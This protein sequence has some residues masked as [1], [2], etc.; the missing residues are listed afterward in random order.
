[1]D[2]TKKRGSAAEKAFFFAVASSFIFSLIYI[3]IRA[4]LDEIYRASTEYRIMIFQSA[5]GLAMINLPTIMRKLFD[6]NIPAGFSIIFLLFLWSAIFAGEVLQFYYRIPMWDDIL[7][8]ASSMMAT[9]LG[10]SLVYI[11]SGT[12]ASKDRHLSPLLVSVFSATF[13][14]FIGVLWE[15]YEYA[16]DGILSLN[17]QKFAV[18]SHG[19]PDILRD[20][21]GRAALTDTMNDL[22]VD[23]LGALIISILGYISLKRSGKLF[24]SF[25]IYVKTDTSNE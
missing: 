9:V 15:I 1:M 13:S 11:L 22:I 16:F 23:T 24:N 4:S 3:P 6:W 7:H 10:F 19:S 2:K 25:R 8:L 12:K 14:V 21:S 18:E 17:M 5:F 20:L